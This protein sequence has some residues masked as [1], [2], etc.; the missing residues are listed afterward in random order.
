MLVGT[1][2]TPSSPAAPIPGQSPTEEAAPSLPTRPPYEG[3]E[4]TFRTLTFRPAEFIPEYIFIGVIFLYALLSYIG[5]AENRSHAGAWFTANEAALKSEFALFG[6]PGDKLFDED[7]G[8]D[9][10]GWGSGRRGV[11]DVVVNVKTTAKHDLIALAYQTGR[12]L[13][14]FTWDSGVNR[15]VSDHSDTAFLLETVADTVF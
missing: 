5:S 9:F 12:G 6:M 8:D 10:I 14:D 11:K 7:G 13:A 2:I 1:P 15:V 4:Y 3:L